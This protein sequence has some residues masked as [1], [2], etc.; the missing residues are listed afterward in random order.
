MLKHFRDSLK[1]PISHLEAINQVL[2]GEDSRV[3]TDFLSVDVRQPYNRCPDLLLVADRV[4]NI[5]AKHEGGEPEA[6]HDRRHSS[7]IL[8]CFREKEEITCSGDWDNVTQNF[9]D[10]MEAMNKTAWGLT[11]NG[12]SFIA[13]HKIHKS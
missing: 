6:E 11:E 7:N 12:F 5:S 1:I 13:A 10:E 8:D 2:L 3:I 9:S 4:P